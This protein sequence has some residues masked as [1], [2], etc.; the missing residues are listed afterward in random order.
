MDI[1]LEDEIANDPEK[2]QGLSNMSLKYLRIPS[3]ARASA[4]T[5]FIAA[6]A[7][8]Q[9]GPIA[10][11]QPEPPSVTMTSTRTMSLVAAA[12]A[13]G[14]TIGDGVDERQDRER[15]A[16]DRARDE[17]ERDRDRETRAYE[18]AREQMDQAKYDRAVE[19]FSEVAAMKGAR[20]DAALYWKAWSQNKAGQRAEALTTIS[21]LTRDYP[22]SRYLT[23]SR[24][25]E[26]EVRR[27]SGQPAT[28]DKEI[29]DDLK[30]MAINALL[31]SDA[32][33]AIPYL[34]KLLEGTASPKLKSRALFVLAQS[35]SEKA[36]EVLKGIAKGSSTPELQSRAIDYLGQAGGRESRAT[37]A[38]IYGST[39]DVDVKRRI[40]RAFMVAGEK[41]RLLSAAQT[42][43]NPELRSEA[44]QQLGVM[45]AH[46][47]LW[48]L[49]QKETA[50]DVKKRIIQAMFVGGNVTRLLELAKTEKDP[51]LRRTAVRNLGVMDSK[52]TSD[53]LVEIYNTDKDPAIRKAV[54]QGLFQQSNATALVDLA[55]KEQDIS[56]KKDIVQKL[57]VMG[58][59]PAATA[60][61]I[62]I[63]NGK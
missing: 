35:N 7:L 46:E 23:Q 21:T 41:D 14:M 54:I 4:L 44:V 5:F 39:S 26:A 32:A 34:Q 51:E 53:A 10:P 24:Q 1:R 11:A 2:T 15:A 62:E 55:R 42:E 50:V 16:A 49:Y 47:E 3:V 45:G 12:I 31:D 13:D 30:L 52:R 22:K 36:R 40:L 38:E 8:A 48:V 27:D 20:A 19:R 37:L 6:P 63:L 33:Q 25:L 17:A 43:Q 59:N 29:D 56:M 9:P 18:Q 28:P 61:M 60:Y 57:S 58:G